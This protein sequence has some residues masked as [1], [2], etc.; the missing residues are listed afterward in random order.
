MTFAP[1]QIYVNPNIYSTEL[2]NS[3]QSFQQSSMPLRKAK[4][5]SRI[6]EAC[7]ILTRLG[8][9]S[10]TEEITPYNSIVFFLTFVNYLLARPPQKP[11][12]P[13]LH[14]DVTRPLG[15]VMPL[16]LWLRGLFDSP[17]PWHTLDK[18]LRAVDSV[19]LKRCAF[20]ANTWRESWRNVSVS[21]FLE[22]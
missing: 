15:C 5:M 10:V 21:L 9:R 20:S 3:P 16:S 2:I 14:H 6:A 12:A 18:T 4:M 19:I 11:I 7:R 13:Y 22:I 17:P 8:I 1:N